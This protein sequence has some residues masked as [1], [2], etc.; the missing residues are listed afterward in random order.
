MCFITCGAGGEAT[1]SARYEFRPSS[2]TE[3]EREVA[4][5]LDAAFGDAAPVGFGDVVA[6]TPLPAVG[7]GA[8]VQAESRCPDEVM[9]SPRCTMTVRFVSGIE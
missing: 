7:P 5:F 1:I 6:R 4:R 8:Y 2:T 9:A 3:A